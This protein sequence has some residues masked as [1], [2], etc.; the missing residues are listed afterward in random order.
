MEIF[1]LLISFGGLITIYEV[2]GW[3]STHIGIKNAEEQGEV[4]RIVMTANSL[5]YFLSWLIGMIFMSGL[6]LVITHLEHNY[7][8]ASIYL[9]LL[10]IPALFVDNLIY[11]TIIK[12]WL[13][14]RM[15]QNLDYQKQK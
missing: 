3:I 2:R 11:S 9:L 5:G 13:D 15:Q 6:A 10:M 14:K 4:T 12:H 1:N 8:L 7:T